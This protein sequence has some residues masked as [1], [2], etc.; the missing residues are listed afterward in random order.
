M[1]QSS[2]ALNLS[3][4][5]TEIK[6][7]IDGEDVDFSVKGK[8]NQPVSNSLGILGFGTVWILFS[9]IFLYISLKGILEGEA[10]YTEVDG[11]ETLVS[12]DNLEALFLPILVVS[13]FILTGIGMLVWAIYSIFRKGAYFIGTPSRL[14][15]IQ[16]D[17]ISAY[18]WEQFT[19][20]I[21][22]DRKSESLSLQLRT[23]TTISSRTSADIFQHDIIY[24]SG[25][26]NLLEI[27][28]ICRKR[29]TDNPL[30]KSH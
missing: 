4:L 10:V 28:K 8:R 23:G 14:L 18:Q 19:G 20:T 16:K 21:I 27:E 24:I 12:L 6:S 9:F 25:I 5:S 3:S 13:V 30:A 11:V 7:I 17:K 29:I 1:E 26:S 15:R 22:V 2:K